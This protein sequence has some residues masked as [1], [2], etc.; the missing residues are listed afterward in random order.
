MKLKSVKYFLWVNAL[1]FFLVTACTKDKGAPAPLV[2][3]CQP[4][5]TRD[6]RPVI[7]TRC[8]LTGCHVGNFPFGDFTKDSVFKIRVVNGRVKTLV[9]DEK[10]MPPANASQLTGEELETLKCWIDNGASFD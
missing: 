4:Q 10:L 1:N 5:Y 8:A 2:T 6:I 7:E 3:K 9:I